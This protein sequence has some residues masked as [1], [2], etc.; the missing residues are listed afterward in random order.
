[1]SL[2]RLFTDHPLHAEGQVPLTAAQAHY[3]HTVLRCSIGD[4]VLI[5]NGIDGEWQAVIDSLNRKSGALVCGQQ[6]QVQAR[7]ADIHLLFAP[8]KKTRTDFIVEK[9]CEMGCAS[10]TPV[11]TEFTNTTR[12]NADRLRAIM[13]EAAEQCGITYIPILNPVKKLYDV[14]EDS[15]K[16]LLFC[17]ERRSGQAIQ[18]VLQEQTYP[19]ACVLIGPEGGF[20]DAEVDML[21][22]LP[23]AVPV[24]LGPRVLRA[25]TAVVAALTACQMFKGDWKQ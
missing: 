1:M 25:E 22:R 13:I 12:V 3:L 7:P 15:T 17:N 18:T 14:A 21:A 19:S 5:F 9:A 10:V 23:Q 16:L 2:A 20:S 4:A 6:T 11:F 8:I 24:T